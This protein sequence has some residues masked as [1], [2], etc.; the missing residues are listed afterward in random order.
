MNGKASKTLRRLGLPKKDWR[1]LSQ[2]QRHKKRV[3]A[4][5]L[6]AIKPLSDRLIDKNTW[7]LS[8]DPKAD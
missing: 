7:F 5:Q 4:A 6:K 8:S 1:K 3:I 2:A